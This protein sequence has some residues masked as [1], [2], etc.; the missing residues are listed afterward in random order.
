MEI[1]L[2]QAGSKEYEAIV[3]LRIRALLEPIGIPASYIIPEK[4]KHDLFIGAW[5]DDEL[6]GCC[7]LTH[8]D[9]DTVQLR[10]MAVTPG[11]QGKGVG[12]AIISFAEQV[13]R[14]R[15]YQTLML[16]ARDPVIG[17][18]RQCGYTISGPQFF[19]VGMGHHKM[20]RQLH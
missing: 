7:V 18:Y 5:N 3:A 17:F 2:A 13:A 4:E 16:H 10:Q 6:I 14:E 15:G 1:R 12:R 20:Q 19:E 11:L 8:R 9:D